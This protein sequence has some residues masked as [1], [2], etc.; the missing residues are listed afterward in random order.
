VNVILLALLPL[1]IAR[2]VQ[3]HCYSFSID[4]FVAQFNLSSEVLK[5]ADERARFWIV[6]P[7]VVFLGMIA[8]AV[9][10]G[11][12]GLLWGVVTGFYWWS[13]NKIMT[14]ILQLKARKK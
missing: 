13:A 3:S 9:K 1:L 12:L 8:G 11:I 2:W 4:P 14:D 7:G 6:V 10:F 5:K